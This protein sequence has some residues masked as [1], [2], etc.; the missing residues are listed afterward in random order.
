MRVFPGSA[1]RPARVLH[2]S[3]ATEPTGSRRRFGGKHLIYDED[4]QSGRNSDPHGR[5]D[6]FPAGG[7]R[8]GALS[9]WPARPWGPG[10]HTGSPDA[11]PPSPESPEVQRGSTRQG[12]RQTGTGWKGLEED[13]RPPP[14]A[15]APRPHLWV[16]LATSPLVP[17]TRRPQNSLPGRTATASSVKDTGREDEPRHT[18]ERGR[19]AECDLATWLCV[20]AFPPDPGRGPRARAPRPAG[21]TAAPGSRLPGAIWPN[22][23]WAQRRDTGHLGFPSMSHSPF[24]GKMTHGTH[25]YGSCY[26]PPTVSRCRIRHLTA[27]LRT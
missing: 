23:V 5:Q 3:G 17:R 16:L 1:V 27:Q 15:P 7:R 14:H 24:P 22:W 6:D 12:C 10:P 8:R 20:H 26:G 4:T 19:G 25:C 13:L 9:I 2:G 11:S 18:S 21:P